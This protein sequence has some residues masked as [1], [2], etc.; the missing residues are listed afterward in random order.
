MCARCAEAGLSR[1]FCAAGAV[2]EGEKERA[3]S[4]GSS[5]APAG[6]QSCFTMLF[7]AAHHLTSLL[8]IRVREQLL[9]GSA[10]CLS[11]G[12]YSEVEPVE[13]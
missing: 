3:R 12:L 4:T 1:G 11:D 7:S 13:F 8:S 9:S 6:F 10:G 2:R 5:R